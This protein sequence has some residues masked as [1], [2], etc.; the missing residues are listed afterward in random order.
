MIMRRIIFLLTLLVSIFT[1]PSCQKDDNQTVNELTCVVIYT[2]VTT[3]SGNDGSITITVK[4]GNSGYNYSISSPNLTTPISNIS[5]RFTTLKAGNYIVKVTD[6]KQKV[7][8]MTVNITEPNQLT[9]DVTS[10]NVTTNGGNNGSITIK[11]KTGNG[12]YN[13]TVN[14]TSNTTGVFT[15]LVAGVYNV[16]VTD[17]KNST[18]NSSVTITETVHSP[19]LTVL[20]ATDITKSSATLNGSFNVF[21]VSSKVYFLFGPVNFIEHK[22]PDQTYNSNSLS[23]TSFNTLD[24]YTNPSLIFQPNTTIYYKM[25]IENS[26]GTFSSDIL[27]F[28]TSFDQ[29]NINSITTSPLSPTIMTFN[30]K[31]NPNGG[32]TTVKIE[33][34]TSTS[35]GNSTTLP[36]NITGYTLTDFTTNI[37]GLTHSITYYYKVSVTN[38]S[39]TTT[40]EGSFSISL[41][42]GSEM[43]GGII[44]YNSNQNGNKYVMVVQK[45]DYMVNGSYLH[46]WNWPTSTVSSQHIA[47]V[48]PR[49]DDPTQY[50]VVPHKEHL[51]DIYSDVLDKITPLFNDNTSGVNNY[52]WVSNVSTN[53]PNRMAHFHSRDVIGD[54]YSNVFFTEAW[55]NISIRVR[56]VTKYTY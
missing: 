17:S 55:V 37:T 48:L 39:G 23:T 30:G 24:V 1:I 42:V 32:N 14:T 4:T 44:F 21:G 25:V 18:F 8:T 15:N 40:S 28:T 26:N 20:P 45:T 22:T 27:S 36:N 19:V 35:Y 10:T 41:T 11:V 9:C 56:L 51:K 38:G 6:S 49:T 47:N 43:G 2:N 52:Y 34:G 46:L 50:W 53:Y 33:Y 12:G 54:P 29:P 3:T 16:K 7:F 31:V 5:G 13:Y